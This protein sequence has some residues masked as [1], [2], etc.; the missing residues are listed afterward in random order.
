LPSNAAV[1]GGHPRRN[2]L[3]LIAYAP[4]SALGFSVS[5]TSTALLKEWGIGGSM[6]TSCAGLHPRETRRRLVRDRVP[7]A[8]R[9]SLVQN[10]IR[11]QFPRM[12]PAINRR[13]VTWSVISGDDTLSRFPAGSPR[14]PQYGS[15]ARPTQR[16][17]QPYPTQTEAS[18]SEQ[19]LRPSERTGRR[20]CLFSIR[21]SL[22]KRAAPTTI[23]ARTA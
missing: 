8:Q 14:P 9:K 10:T 11:I 12:T 19:A 13:S 3:P 16:G 22:G 1:S 21:R 6:R 5:Q 17:V 23:N 20:A 7:N 15:S 18:S 4:S 2:S